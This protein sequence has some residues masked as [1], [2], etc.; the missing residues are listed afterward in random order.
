MNPAHARLP[1][2]SREQPQITREL[3]RSGGTP[4]VHLSHLRHAETIHQ[5]R[6]DDARHGRLTLIRM[7][8][9]E[10]MA[11]ARRLGPLMGVPNFAC[12]FKKLAMSHVS[13]AYFPQC[14]MS[15]F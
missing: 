12:Q 2:V 8:V 14:H 1:V 9:K 7:Q 4:E 5:S 15:N 10:R 11:G 6:D 13:V 3:R